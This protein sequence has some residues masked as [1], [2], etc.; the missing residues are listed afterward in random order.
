[1]SFPVQ[2]HMPRRRSGHTTAVTIGGEQFS[3]TANSCG[4]G[5]LDEVFVRWGKQGSASAGMMDAYATALSLCLQRGVPLAELLQPALGLYFAPAGH[6]DDPQI[7]RVRSAVD[8]IA[9]RLAIDWLP[10]GERAAIG[11][12]TIYELAGQSRRE[13][14]A[15]PERN[16]SHTRDLPRL[17]VVTPRMGSPESSRNDSDFVADLAR[18]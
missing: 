7:P 3:L 4:D 14:A 15:M 18:R 6:T 13:L 9:R 11:V 16:L 12:F 10:Y 8:Y 5:I 1:M 17:K 2:Q